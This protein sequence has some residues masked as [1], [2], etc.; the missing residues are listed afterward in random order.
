M[1][2]KPTALRFSAIV[3]QTQTT[4]RR[5]ASSDDYGR[6][7]PASGG[8]LT[9]S[10]TVERP[11]EPVK[12]SFNHYRGWPKLQTFKSNADVDGA[13]TARIRAQVEKL[14]QA[15][16]PQVIAEWEAAV[17]E[18]ENASPPELTKAQEREVSEWQKVEGLLP[19][20]TSHLAEREAYDEALEQSLTLSRQ[21]HML[22]GMGSALAGERVAVVM[23]PSNDSIHQMFAGMSALD[24]VIEGNA[25]LLGLAEA[26]GG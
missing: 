3:D 20:L 23:V 9:I 14:Q 19:E 21:F 15:E 10:M 8:D 4:K 13:T 11:P 18:D 16:K 2:T 17:A 6:R 7:K 26:A 24:A 25:E 22:V 1:T 12:P 5:G